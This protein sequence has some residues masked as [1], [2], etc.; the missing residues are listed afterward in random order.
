MKKVLL[1]I[2]VFLFAFNVNALSTSDVTLKSCIDG[3]TANFIVDGEE[4]KARFLSIN[5]PEYEKEEYGKEASNYTCKLLK[6]AKSI[7]LEFDLLATTDKYDRVLVWVWVDKDLLQEKLVSEGYAEVAYVYDKY[8]YADSL[9]LVQQDAIKKKKN[10]WSNGKREQDYCGGIDTSK[11]TNI[12]D[13]DLFVS[14][15]EQDQYSQEEA[16]KIINQ[17]QDVKEKVD[18]ITNATTKINDYLYNNKEDISNVLMYLILGIAGVY[19]LL[20]TIREM[21]K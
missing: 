10:I 7:T 16:E 19:V 14:M 21:K 13:Y 5:T 3:D 9:C 1:F 12:I 17:I 11:V 18:S 4:I 20:K 6:E 2:S 15:E 8:K